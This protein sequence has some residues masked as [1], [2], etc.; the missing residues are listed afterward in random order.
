MSRAPR[1]GDVIEIVTPTGLAYAHFTHKHKQY[2]SLLRVMRGLHPTRPSSFKTI[3]EGEAQFS[4]FF[5][6]GA[7]CKREVVHIV[8]NEP[9]PEA[10]QAFP[11]FRAGVQNAQGIV[12]VWWLW[13]GSSEWKVGALQPG[14][15]H[16]PIRGVW[17]DTLL[18]ERICSGWSCEQAT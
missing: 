4:A 17:N 18:I 2:G 8:G 15:E 3:L 16:Y 12:E 1:I 6:L 7:A 9:L 14:M 11:V 13:D 5:P 10:A